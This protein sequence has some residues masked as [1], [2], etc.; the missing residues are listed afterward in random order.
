MINIENLKRSAK[1]F[2]FF[3]V[4]V[5]ILCFAYLIP[6][7]GKSGGWIASQYTIKYCATFLLFFMTG[8][9]VTTKV[10]EIKVNYFFNL[11]NII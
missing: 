1:K 3:I 2:W 7:I 5:C 11:I 10:N 9:M 6:N 8:F 4:L